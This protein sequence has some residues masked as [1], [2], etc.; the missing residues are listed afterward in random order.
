MVPFFGAGMWNFFGTSQLSMIVNKRSEAQNENMFLLANEFNYWSNLAVSRLK[1]TGLPDTVDERLLNMGLYFYGHVAFFEH[2]TLGLIALPCNDGDRFNLFGQPIQVTASGYDN[3][4]TLSNVNTETGHQFEFVRY[5]PSGM[6][7]AVGVMC[8]VARM[9]D[10]MRSV[11]VLAQRMK[12][13]YIITCEEK[14]RVTILNILKKIKDNEDLV[15]GLKDYGLGNKSIN[16]APTPAVTDFACLWD[17]Y[18]QYETRLYTI[19]GIDNKGYEKKERLLVDEVNANNMVIQMADT[20]NLKELRLGLA[21]VNKTFGTQIS[22][23][24][25]NKT[26][27]NIEGM[28]ELESQ[29]PPYT[30]VRGGDT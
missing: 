21:R 24:I 16:I 9:V 5:T 3:S 28:E 20:V 27:Y 7:Q 4:F 23:E 2:G 15:L 10:L 30:Y 25:E 6:P 1:W 18:K 22:V 26:M 11:D 13:P 17:S 29:T 14:E 12:R 8:L 19:L